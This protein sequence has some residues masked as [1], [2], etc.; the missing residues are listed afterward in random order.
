MRGVFLGVENAT[1]TGLR[2]LARGANLAAVNRAMKA[3]T[4]RGMAVTYNLL[5]F[6]P[7]ATVEEV[8]ANVAFVRA[9]AELPFDFGR[10]EI[11]AGSPLERQTLQEGLRCGRWPQWDYR[12]RNAGA[13]RAFEVYRDTFRR[14]RGAYSMLM[15]QLIA[16][17]YHAGVVR[18]LCP[19]PAAEAAG[20]RVSGLLGRSNLVIADRIEEMLRVA[21]GSGSEEALERGLEEHCRGVMAEAEK[22]AELLKRLQAAERVFQWFGIQP[23]L[24]GTRWLPRMLRCDA[25]AMV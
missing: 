13:Q 23:M 7:H 14:R 9:H 17:A 21:E 10:A 20:R 8:Q 12:L 6:H 18:R 11:V 24:Q 25:E 22:L 4:R 2:A 1:E 15:H 3:L 19:G 16:L 5:V